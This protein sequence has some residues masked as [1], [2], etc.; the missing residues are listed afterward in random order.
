MAGMLNT[1][2][3]K[4]DFYLVEASRQGTASFTTRA[5]ASAPSL[6]RRMVTP[7]ISQKRSH[8]R[9]GIRAPDLVPAG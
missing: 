7:L 1:S 3:G 4:T 9:L 5:A 8:C 6:P 2:E